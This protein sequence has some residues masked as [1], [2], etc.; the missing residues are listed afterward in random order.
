MLGSWVELQDSS[1]RCYLAPC[2]TKRQ[3]YHIIDV[4][5]PCEVQYLTSYCLISRVIKLESGRRSYL[6]AALKMMIE[7]R[8]PI[9]SIIH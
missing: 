9:A 8:S 4:F 2:I 3:A 6:A 5:F 1:W 7:F